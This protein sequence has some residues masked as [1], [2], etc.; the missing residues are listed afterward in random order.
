MKKLLIMRHGKSAWDSEYLND[1]D[2]PLNE[3]GKKN[4]AEMGRFLLEECG[5]P[6]LILTSSAKRAMETATLAAISLSYP[7]EKIEAGKELYLAETGEI[8]RS[9]ANI[10]AEVNTCLLIGHNP[11]LTDLVNYFGLKL[12]NLPTASVVHMEFDA[13]TWKDI[14]P[15]NARFQW[16]KLAKEL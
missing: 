15:K 2:R 14:S 3:R 1:Y 6:E 5:K 7:Q 10:H 9:I 12:D 13:S 4:A 16:I 11:G 8:M